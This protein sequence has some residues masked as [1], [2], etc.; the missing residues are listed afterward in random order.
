MDDNAVTDRFRYLPCALHPALGR[1]SWTP[2]TIGPG[3][4]FVVYLTWDGARVDL[5]HPAG[6]DHAVRALAAIRGVVV[7]ESTSVALVVYDGWMVQMEI[8]ALVEWGEELVGDFVNVP[9]TPAARREALCRCICAAL[10]L[11]VDVVFS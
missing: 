7:P 6:W 9:E 5:S 3:G 1:P 8:D 11:N 2:S 4:P 10:N